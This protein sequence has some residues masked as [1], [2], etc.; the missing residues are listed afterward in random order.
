MLKQFINLKV[1]NDVH[2]IN[3]KLER[4]FHWNYTTNGVAYIA[5]QEALEALITFTSKPNRAS[6]TKTTTVGG[7]EIGGFYSVRMWLNSPLITRMRDKLKA[8]RKKNK[9]KTMPQ[10]LAKELTAELI[11]VQS[12]IYLDYL[13][14]IFDGDPKEK[15]KRFRRGNGTSITTTGRDFLNLQHVSLGEENKINNKETE[16]LFLP[17]QDFPDIPD[18]IIKILEE[19]LDLEVAPYEAPDQTE[20][21]K[22][23]RLICPNACD[24]NDM[25]TDI[26]IKES[27]LNIARVLLGCTKHNNSLVVETKDKDKD[28]AKKKVVK[29]SASRKVSPNGK[30]PVKV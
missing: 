25:D 19:L 15:P 18:E 21:E 7:K 12:E 11:G 20:P 23:F 1:N 4:L 8:Y 26:K 5:L 29:V 22:K 6:Q 30:V 3:Q 27:D 17:Q 9:S 16:Q 13:V 10:E 14:A 28:K 24:L 2:N